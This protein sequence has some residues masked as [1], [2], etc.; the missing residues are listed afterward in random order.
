MATQEMVRLEAV[1]HGEVQGVS[2]RYYTQQRARSLGLRGY[3]RNRSDGA[4]EVVVEG[5]RRAVEELFA[6]L[7]T[8]PAMADVRSVDAVWGAPSGRWAS[9]EVRY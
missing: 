3:V 7:H 2:F 4:V 9:F 1:V 5:A 6:W 8:G